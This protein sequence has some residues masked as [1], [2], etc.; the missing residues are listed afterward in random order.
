[1]SYNVYSYFYL[2]IS[3]EYCNAISVHDVARSYDLYRAKPQCYVICI[4]I[5][6]FLLPEELQNIEMRIG[7]TTLLIDRLLQLFIDT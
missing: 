2:L 5:F 6:N 3:A 4:L 7:S 1:M